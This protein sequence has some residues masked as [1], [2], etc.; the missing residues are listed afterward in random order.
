MTLTVNELILHLRHDRQVTLD[1]VRGNWSVAT[2]S[3]FE[4]GEIELADS[5]ISQMAIP[6]GLDY[7]DLVIRYFLSTESLDDWRYLASEMWDRKKVEA[8][9]ANIESLQ[10]AGMRN[11]FLTVAVQVIRELLAIHTV[12]RQ[13][14]RPEIVVKLSKYLENLSDFSRLEG[15]LFSVCLEYVPI[16]LGWEWVRRQIDM[17]QRGDAS[18]QKIRRFISFC[19]NAAERAAIERQFSTMATI[20]AEMRRLDATIPENAIQRNNIRMMETLLADLE[21]P[22]P[23]NHRRFIEVLQANALLFTPSIHESM[24]EY[25]IMQGWA[26]APDFE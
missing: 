4:R 10:V 17:L 24:I 11:G 5:V 3:R 23:S 25:T 26:S 2:L 22:S 14:M 12:G 9:L 6:L 15:V 21:L 8:L 20:V 1:E 18:P 19:A 16:D 13:S 7:E